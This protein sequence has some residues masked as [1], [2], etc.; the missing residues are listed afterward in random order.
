[1]YDSVFL[2]L[3]PERRVG[4]S[5][6]FASLI[7]NSLPRLFSPLSSI[8]ITFKKPLAR[9]FEYFVPERGVEPP[10]PKILAPKASASTNSATQAYL[11][12]IYT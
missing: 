12:L 2:F 9:L 11:I 4:A 7:K 6:K 10:H 8:K 1:M 3:V 5:S